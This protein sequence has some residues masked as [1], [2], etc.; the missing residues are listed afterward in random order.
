MNGVVMEGYK[1]LVRGGVGFYD[2][3]DGMNAGESMGVRAC[4]REGAPRD[5]PGHAG[6]NDVTS[7]LSASAFYGD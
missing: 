2:I 3:E 5:G 4:C 7:L 6:Q 1:R